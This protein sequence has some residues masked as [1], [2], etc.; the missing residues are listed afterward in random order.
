MQKKI[1]NNRQKRQIRGLFFLAILCFIFITPV[2]AFEVSVDTQKYP[3]EVY[4][5]YLEYRTKEEQ[6]ITKGKAYIS[7]QDMKISGDNIQANTGTED[8]FAQGN[9]DFWKGYDQV[10]GDFIV[11][12]MKTGKGWMRNAEVRKSRNYFKLQNQKTNVF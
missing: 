8:I 10:S 4:G 9:V 5:D 2:F 1:I 12:N 11:Y 6:V 3:V 7:Y